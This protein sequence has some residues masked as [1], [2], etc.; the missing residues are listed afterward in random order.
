M[1]DEEEIGSHEKENEN[2]V[3]RPAKRRAPVQITCDNPTQFTETPIAPEV[4][5]NPV[6]NEKDPPPQTESTV[7]MSKFWHAFSKFEPNPKVT[8]KSGKKPP[9]PKKISP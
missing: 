8:S 7:F 3:N 5:R 9:P 6:H 1:S 2:K 4:Q